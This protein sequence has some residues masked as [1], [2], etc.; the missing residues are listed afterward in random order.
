MAPDTPPLSPRYPPIP[1]SDPAWSPDPARR[2][3]NPFNPTD[4]VEDL[5]RA[6]NAPA[7]FFCPI[8]L[9]LMRDPVMAYDGHSYERA[10]IERWFATR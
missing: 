5:A 4:D 3:R 10:A 2:D 7:D 8:S 6:A 1:S 9:E